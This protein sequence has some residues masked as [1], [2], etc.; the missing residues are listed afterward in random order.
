LRVF[1]AGRRVPSPTRAGSVAGQLLRT[2]L[3]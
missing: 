1:V 3:R 2:I